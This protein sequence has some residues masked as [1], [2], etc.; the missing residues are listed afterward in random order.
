MKLSI[1][2]F[3]LLF[4]ITPGQAQTPLDAY[5]KKALEQ[6]IGVRQQE[7]SLEQSEADLKIARQQFLPTLSVNARY[8]VAAGGRSFIIPVG[9]LVNPIYA[10]LNA[11]NDVAEAAAPDY[12]TLSDYPAINN[13]EENFLR[14]TEQETVVRLQMPVFN[15]AIV[16]N[17]RIQENILAAGQLSVEA[18]KRTLVKEVKV[19][20]YSYLQARKGAQ[21]VQNAR[22][23][24]EENLR[25]TQSL[26]THHKVTRD[27]VYR[28]QAELSAVAQQLTEARKQEKVARALFNTLLNRPLDAAIEAPTTSALLP[29]PAF[30]L[31][32]AQAQALRQREEF[33]QLSC[34]EAV[35]SQELA[36]AKGNRLP[37]VNL[38]ADYGI[39]G[40]RYEI[41]DNARF[42][43]GSVVMNVPIFD[44]KNNTRTQKARIG[45]LQM[46]QQR[47][48]A[49][50]QVQLQ[51]LQA[52]YELEAAKEQIEQSKAA[53][54]AAE[55]GFRLI[56]KKYEQGQ[57]NLLEFQQSRNQMTT[58]ALQQSIAQLQYQVRHANLEQ[59]T[60][61][62]PI[63]SF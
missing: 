30:T 60:A 24:L 44:A 17:Q 9:D 11:L 8:S 40:T 48:A 19:A 51:V 12:P 45:Q 26:E 4:S 1:I 32:D 25:T 29:G 28:A 49:K 36:I 35:R 14:P 62:Y 59:A 42:F 33:D 57:A 58:A 41:D 20:Y 34:Y 27:A 10:N 43:L 6:N 22:A 5:L 23:L 39:Q 13:V 16:H 15:Q 18:Y 61:T 53:Y 52:Y 54:A 3:L 50:Q 37:T 55:Q 63:G 21:I 31:Q 38:Q 2:L 56:R 47:A 46:E 7:L